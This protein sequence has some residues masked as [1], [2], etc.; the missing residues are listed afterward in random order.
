MVW[1][2]NHPDAQGKAF[3]KALRRAQVA[4]QICVSLSKRCWDIMQVEWSA[5]EDTPDSQS[6]L[7]EG[8]VYRLPAFNVMLQHRMQRDGSAAMGIAS[9]PA[10]HP[11]STSLGAEALKSALQLASLRWTALPGTLEVIQRLRPHQPGE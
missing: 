2:Q 9:Q 4:V 11:R 10:L 3:R 8:W 1:S 6:A 5:C 7:F